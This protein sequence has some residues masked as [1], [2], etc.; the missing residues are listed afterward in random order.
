MS[1]RL[2]RLFILLE[3][4]STP[5][6]RKS[7]AQQLGEVQRLHPHELH[8]LLA[9]VLKYLRHSLWETRIA[10]GQAIE[11]IL[12]NVPEWQPSPPP[13]AQD[14]AAAAEISLDSVIARVPR[15]ATVIDRLDISSV[16][17]KGASLLA[18]NVDKYEHGDEA[19]GLSD[20]ERISL[21]KQRLNEHLGLDRVASLVMRGEALYTD[22]DLVVTGR[23]A[24]QPQ[25]AACKDASEIMKE[26]MNWSLTS[27]QALV[28]RRRALHRVDGQCSGNTDTANGFSTDM[29]GYGCDRSGDQPPCKK[30][31]TL[32][33]AVDQPGNPDR[34]VVDE[35]L[36]AT[37]AAAYDSESETW[38]FENVC[39]VLFNDLFHANWEVRHGAATG[40]REVFKAHGKAAGWVGGATSAE[41]G[42]FNQLFLQEAAVRLLCVLAL[43]RFGDYVSD[44][45]VAPVRETCAQVVGVV[46]R[47][48]D[49]A[50]VMAV[51]RVLLQVAQCSSAPWE[52]RHGALLGVKYVLATR[53]DMAASMMAFVLPT[54]LLSLKDSVDDVRAVAAACL[55]PAADSLP[56]LLADHQMAAVMDCLWEALLELDDLTSSTNSVMSLLATLVCSS[57]QA[58]GRS[59]YLADLAPRLFPFLRHSII[60]VR[61]STLEAFSALL[62]CQGMVSPDGQPW[63]IPILQ[64]A[65]RHIFMRCLLEDVD[66]LQTLALQTWYK[67]LD[68]VSRFD[69]TRTEGEVVLSQA[70]GPWLNAWMCLMMQ[71]ARLPFD[72]AII[73]AVTPV[74]CASSRQPLQHLSGSA[75]Q[76]PDATTP[77]RIGAPSD[78]ARHDSY[79]GGCDLLSSTWAERERKIIVTRMTCAKCIG[80]L[81]AYICAAASARAA[82]AAARL[83]SSCSADE[84]GSEGSSTAAAAAAAADMNAAAVRESITRLLVYYLATR[85]AVQRTCAALITLYWAETARGE[86]LCPVAFPPTEIYDKLQSCLQEVIFYD[87]V[88]SAFASLQAECRD[89]AATVRHDGVVLD[90]RYAPGKIVSVDDMLALASRAHEVA[91][92]APKTQKSKSARESYME[93]AE[94][95]RSGAATLQSDQQAL[96]VRTQVVMAA[97]ALTQRQLPAS[98][99]PVIRPLMEAIK[100]E[101]VMQ[102][103]E[104][105]ASSLVTI[106]TLCSQREPCPNPKVLKNL[107][108][109]LCADGSVSP[110]VDKVLPAAQASDVVAPELYCDAHRGILSLTASQRSAAQ[111]FGSRRRGPRPKTVVPSAAGTTPKAGCAVDASAAVAPPSVEGGETA[112][113]G[114][115][116]DQ[117]AALRVQHLGAKCALRAIAESFDDAQ[118]KSVVPSFV[119]AL[120]DPLHLVNVC[121]I[122]PDA[123]LAPDGGSG[124]AVATA[125]DLVNSLHL[126]ECVYPALRGAAREAVASRLDRIVACLSSPWTAVRHMA[127]RCLACICADSPGGAVAMNVVVESVLPLLSASHSD[128]SR[129]GT[130]EAVYNIVEGLGFDVAPYVA[131]LVVPVLG[132]MSDQDAAVQATA[133]QCFA[134]LL[135][136]MPLE[137]GIPNPPE[138]KSSVAAKKQQERAFLEQLLGGRKVEDYGIPVPVRTDLRK[139]QQD[140]VNWLS[141][142]NKYKLHGI[143][144]D[145]MGLGKTL[146]S[147]CI[148]AADHHQRQA[149]YEATQQPDCAPLPSI[150]ICPP[151]LTSHWVYEVD[152]FVDK[153]YLNPLNY[154]GPPAERMKLR[155]LFS[156]HNLIVASY[157][158]VRNDIDFFR[159]IRWNYCILD[160]GHIIKNAKSKTTQAVKLLRSNHRLILTGTPVQNDA[161]ELWSLFDFLMPGYLGSERQFSV[162]YSRPILQSRDAK[163]S[164]RDQEAGALAVEALHKQVLPFLLRRVKEDVLQDLP[165]KIIQ[166][167]YCDL[168]PLQAKLYREFGQSRIC[169]ALEQGDDAEPVSSKATALQQD[170]QQPTVKV[171]AEGHVFQALQYLKKVCN[172]PALVLTP[173]HPSYEQTVRDLE[174][175]GSS[176]HGIE[177]AAK[178]TVLRQLLLDCGIGVD[179]SAAGSADCTVV[180][181]HRALVFCQLKTMLDIIEKDLLCIH[182]PTVSYLRLDGSV[183]AASR[184]DVVTKFNADPSID[185]LLLTTNVGGLGLNL[186]GADTVIFVE[187]DWNPMKDLQAMDRAHRIGQKKV[188]NVYRLITKN[189]LEEKILGLQKFKLSI[190]STV[191]NQENSSFSTM[192]TDQLLDLFTLNE[193]QS[194]KTADRAKKSTGQT[195]SIKSVLQGLDELWDS[196]QY[197][198]EYDLNHFMQSHLQ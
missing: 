56:N 67:L 154:A 101:P 51:L 151:T 48:L 32:S 2:D 34:I 37:S 77:T 166:D 135:R 46:V 66:E 127:A 33:V 97:A 142:L 10:A 69:L 114:S 59:R 89:L 15:E 179:T 194:A 150:V 118:M 181:Q 198:T 92:T 96:N 3:T 63:A 39:G 175:Q 93:R 191:V 144:C 108:T 169:K 111:S 115:G 160:E 167:Y 65:L 163:C 41:L 82:A 128:T 35:V 8:T 136:L 124:D 23:D 16:L 61:R 164:Q 155:S 104:L 55:L 123:A 121:G 20:K 117:Q 36:D 176:L 40:L 126:I 62:N 153:K 145:D 84:P 85:S 119:D 54:V 148:L 4:G 83:G 177:Q 7:A 100:K 112:G 71:S 49:C 21:Q 50:G 53:Q 107:C 152:K 74:S 22:E 143:L 24:R 52:A 58:T 17:A 81:C 197:E 78:E 193:K 13:A 57:K 27:L 137:G 30:P 9:K 146:Q 73:A 99:N 149:K 90:D 158:I 120:V 161:L 178:L 188:V 190:A 113:G 130:I 64:D 159:D 106:L 12:R 70:T 134:A 86:G 170:E 79:I 1:S 19:T 125:Q 186:T 129:Q 44:E 28:A 18:A 88:A 29:D 102:V 116:G 6:I 147:I 183:P 60:S 103:Q 122:K 171:K 157:D 185:V 80:A 25:A 47:L 38:P 11:A 196:R 189:T 42:L 168:S 180:N 156:A 165:P 72:A 75:V 138:M 132:C 141:F 173:Q 140:G 98:L 182:M 187:H 110:Q 131:L 94:R 31:K 195:E 192:E 5:V 76:S 43:D 45:V 162:R 109:A 139:Y 174:A 172:H 133:S 91:T 95:L 105:A 14:T 184:H 68:H 87:E 26:Q